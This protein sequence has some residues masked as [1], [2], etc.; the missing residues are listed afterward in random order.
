VHRGAGRC[1]EGASSAHTAQVTG[2]DC[3]DIQP[4]ATPCSDWNVQRR[5][6]ETKGMGKQA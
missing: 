5:V 4:A 6:L 3:N 1:Q 2:R